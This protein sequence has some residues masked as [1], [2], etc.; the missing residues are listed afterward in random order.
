M[1]Q[2]RERTKSGTQVFDIGGV[3]DCCI[4][5]CHISVVFPYS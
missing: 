1:N 2:K 4:D 3:S 5:S